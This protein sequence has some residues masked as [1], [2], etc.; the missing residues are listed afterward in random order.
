MLMNNID[1]R[2]EQQRERCQCPHLH[3]THTNENSKLIVNQN[4]RTM[5]KHEYLTCLSRSNELNTK[6]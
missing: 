6:E 2:I 3:N 4:V 5:N 1:L